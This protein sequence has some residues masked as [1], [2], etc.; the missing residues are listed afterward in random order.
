MTKLQKILRKFYS[1]P[2]SLRYS[3]IE[4]ILISYGCIKI[5]AKGSHMKFKHNLAESDLI[6]PVHKNDCKEF[7]KKCALEFIKDN[8]LDTH[9]EDPDQALHH[10]E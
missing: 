9:Y 8:N 10:H 6:I 5:S 3:Q 1:N 4:K 7:Y 2:A